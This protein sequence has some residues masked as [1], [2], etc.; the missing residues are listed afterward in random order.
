MATKNL[1]T[2]WKE[3]TMKFMFKSVTQR[4]S[5]SKKGLDLTLMEIA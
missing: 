5:V 2:E 1:F 3:N 4:G